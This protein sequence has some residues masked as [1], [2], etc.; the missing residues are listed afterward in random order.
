[1]GSDF[2]LQRNDGLKEEALAIF[3]IKRQK[4]WIMVYQTNK[5]MNT[6]MKTLQEMPPLLGKLLEDGISC[7]E[8]I[9]RTS[10]EFSYCLN[11]PEEASHFI[12][13]D[14][15]SGKLLRSR[16]QAQVP[17][18]IPIFGIWD[19]RGTARLNSSLI[20]VSAWPWLATH[21]EQGRPTNATTTVSL[22]LVQWGL[23]PQS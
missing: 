11:R 23:S 21:A 15:K 9:I 3:D 8:S 1:M 22:W 7:C 12:H 2:P 19:G 10:H 17:G 4:L 13:V 14:P 5:R 20:M 6:Q 18:H 16:L